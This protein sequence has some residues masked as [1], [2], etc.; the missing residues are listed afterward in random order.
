MSAKNKGT[1][2]YTYTLY[3]YIYKLMKAI[4]CKILFCIRERMFMVEILFLLI[5]FMYLEKEKE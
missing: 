3:E 5:K 1:S 4:T 2:M